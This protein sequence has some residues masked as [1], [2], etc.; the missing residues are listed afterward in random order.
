MTAIDFNKKK[1][2]VEELSTVISESVSA[3]VANYKGLTVTDMEA[4]RKSS[5]DQSVKIRVYRNTLIKRAIKD[6]PFAC[7]DETITGQIVVLFSGG[8]LGAPARIL[9]DFKK[10]NEKLDVTGLAID[11]EFYTGDHLSQLADL[12]TKQEALSQL[13][14]V[15]KAPIT[16]MVRTTKEPVAK[17][18]RV[19][20]AVSESKQ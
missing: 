15:M 19:F 2:I 5:R 14:S 8:E 4:L 6:T 20:S 1:E 11:G 12:P 16:K 7:L 18:V 9:R 10:V 17:F 3:A 13:V